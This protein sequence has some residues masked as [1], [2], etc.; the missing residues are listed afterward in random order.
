MSN[1]ISDINKLNLI[2]SD[3]RIYYQSDLEP[4]LDLINELSK[5]S[6]SVDVDYLTRRL[7]NIGYDGNDRAEAHEIAGEVFSHRRFDLDEI[8]NRVIEDSKPR[9]FEKLKESFNSNLDVF[10]ITGAIATFCISMVTLFVAGSN[11]GSDT[12]VLT[13]AAMTNH[14]KSDIDKSTLGDQ[15]VSLELKA[16]ASTPVTSTTLPDELKLNIYTQRPTDLKLKVTYR[17]DALKTFEYLTVS[18][19]AEQDNQITLTLDP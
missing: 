16:K 5:R 11:G 10:I 15:L 4:N 7:G 14:N 17:P 19:K 9:Y 1:S 12:Q 18:T 2:L 6:K 3:F 8:F 13:Q